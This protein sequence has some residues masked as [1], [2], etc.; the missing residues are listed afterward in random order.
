MIQHPPAHT[1]EFAPLYT[2]KTTSPFFSGTMPLPPSTNE[3][4]RPICINGVYRIGPTAELELF[5]A[6]A[7]WKLTE[8]YCDWH[9]LDALRASKRKVPL[10]IEL[11]AYFRTP[12]KRDLDGI[13]KFSIDALFVHLA[14]SDTSL[15]PRL[16]DNQ[17]VDIHP[18]K[19]VDSTDPR[20]EISLSVALQSFQERA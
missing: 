14:K 13:I 12:W 15:R 17:V 3:A 5:K 2:T 8:A 9:T 20:V 7:A 16:N 10:A 19:L 18:V 6:A 4:Y 1:G 11:K